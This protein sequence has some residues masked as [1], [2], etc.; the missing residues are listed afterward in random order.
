M[1]RNL[2]V[3]QILK[4]FSNFMTFISLLLN[5]YCTFTSLEYDEMPNF[6]AARKTC[7]ARSKIVLWRLK[8]EMSSY[9]VGAASIK[10]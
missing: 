2:L 8:I 1:N 4:L 5:Y 9:S 6:I 7:K 10:S 3:Y